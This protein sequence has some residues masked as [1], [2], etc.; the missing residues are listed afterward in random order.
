MADGVVVDELVAAVGD[1]EGVLEAALEAG[2]ADGADL[3]F[4]GLGAVFS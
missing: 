1:G 4:V 2:G 3:F